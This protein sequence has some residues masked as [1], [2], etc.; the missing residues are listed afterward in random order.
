[1]SSLGLAAVVVHSN[2]NFER[3]VNRI[4]MDEQ[5]TEQTGWLARA[6][7]AAAAR[8]KNVFAK[9]MTLALEGKLWSAKPEG[10]ALARSL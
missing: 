10:E 1:M 4:N 2:L 5:E 6:T 8:E 9:N 7:L 3:G